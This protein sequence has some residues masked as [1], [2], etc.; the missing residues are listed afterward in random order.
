MT[1]AAKYKNALVKEFDQYL[2]LM[3]K[4]W[5]FRPNIEITAVA[6]L[7]I[8]IWIKCKKPWSNRDEWCCDTF[9]INAT[10]GKSCSRRHARLA[11]TLYKRIGRKKATD[12]TIDGFNVSSKDISIPLSVKRYPNNEGFRLTAE[13]FIHVKAKFNL[14]GFAHEGQGFYISARSLTKHRKPSR[15][16]RLIVREISNHRNTCDRCGLGILPISARANNRAW[17][18]GMNTNIPPDGVEEVIH[19]KLSKKLKKRLLNKV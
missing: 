7:R 5:E 14:D 19:P 2:D 3:E 18:A 11:P 8:R 16:A 10:T 9:F 17:A 12:Y 6:K 15:V 4:H 1:T 13:P